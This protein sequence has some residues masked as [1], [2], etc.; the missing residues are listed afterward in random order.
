MD[1]K[2]WITNRAM[3]LAEELYCQDYYDLPDKLQTEVYNKAESD[4]TDYYAAEI[5]AAYDRMMEEQLLSQSDE[6]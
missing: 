5:D 4:Y 1:Y 6:G 3:E 2:D